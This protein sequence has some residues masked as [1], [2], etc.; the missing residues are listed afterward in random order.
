MKNFETTKLAKAQ[1]PKHRKGRPSKRNVVVKEVV[2]EVAGL[3]PYEKRLLD[4][5]SGTGDGAGYG[6]DVTGGDGK[7]ENGLMLRLTVEYCN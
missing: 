2:A 1:R 6:V 4:M 5:R 3:L 7:I